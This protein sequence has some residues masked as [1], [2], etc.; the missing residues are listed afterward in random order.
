MRIAT[1]ALLL[2]SAVFGQEPVVERASLWIDTVKQGDMT[3][4]VR[5]LGEITANRTAEAMLPESMTKHVAAG[6]PVSIET[7]EHEKAAGKVS[8]V[9]G[10]VVNGMVAITVEFEGTPPDWARAGAVVD[11]TIRVDQLNNVVYVG[12]PVRSA[13]EASGTIFKLDPDGTHATRVRVEYGRAAVNTVQIRSG[14]LAGD[15]I[16]LSDLS[17]YQGQ[18][19]LRIQ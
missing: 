18:D 15:K 6:Q 13:P 10:S 12:R 17:N 7:R 2:A 4:A 3:I 9:S 8:R 11:C 1:S 14:L 5:G 16:I 19:R